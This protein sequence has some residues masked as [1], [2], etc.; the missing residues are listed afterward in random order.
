MTHAILN[1][2]KKVEPC[3]LL[4]WAAFLEKK[5]NI[6]VKQDQVRQYFIS[7]VFLGLDHS[8]GHEPPLWFE[9]M[10]FSKGSLADLFCDRYTTYEEAE[11]G[12]KDV[13][14]KVKAG[15]LPNKEWIVE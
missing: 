13:L 11:A 2:D 15:S 14:K 1:A 5:E 6:I 8:F 4:T 7:T 12:H 10:I 9:T 3:D